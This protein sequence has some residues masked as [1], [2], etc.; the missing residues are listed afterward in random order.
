M[1]C[2][3]GL[4]IFAVFSVVLLIGIMSVDACSCGATQ[5]ILESFNAAENVIITKAVAVN[6]AGEEENYR[7]VDG[8]T[9]TRMIVEKVFKGN[10]KVGDEMTFAQGGG[11]DCIWTFNEDSVGQKY[12][13]YLGKRGRDQKNWIGLGCGRSSGI[14]GAADDLLYLNKLDKVRGRNRLSGTL[15]FAEYDNIAEPLL[16]GRKIKI[17]GNDKTYNLKTDQNGVYEIYDLPAGKYAIIPE[18]P[19]GWKVNTFHLRYSQDLIRNRNAEGEAEDEDLITEY[20]VKLED[21]KHALLDFHFELDNALRGKVFD[22]NGNPLKNACVRLF[23]P[24]GVTSTFMYKADCTDEGGKFE[25]DEVPPGSYILVVNDEGKISSSEPFKT[26]Y[27]PGVF[28]LEKA[29]IVEVGMADSREDLNIYIPKTE[30][31]ITIEG[32]F[33]YSDGKPVVGGNVIFE[34]AKKDKDLDGSAGARTDQAGHF[35][36]KILKG[37]KGQLFGS[38]YS[39]IGQFENCPKL[40]ALIREKSS[41]T[42]YEPKT[43]EVKIDGEANIYN[44]E[45]KFLFPGCQKAK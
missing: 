17:I 26:L 37:M 36:I 25:M 27:Y 9:S 7:P 11:A 28:E 44:L 1:T 32:A 12:L 39:F 13:F 5:N 14:E 31:L 8:V 18:K 35:S 21:K 29:T 40:E 24:T 4:K 22:P 33:L 10:L 19:P 42:F 43:N 34:P 30:D 38:I 15:K 3:N 6:K 2:R 45:L 20:G 23:P 16:G 41:S